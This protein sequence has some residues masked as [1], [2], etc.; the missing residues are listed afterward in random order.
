MPNSISAA[1]IEFG[2]PNYSVN[3]YIL[4]TVSGGFRQWRIVC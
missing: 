1:I 3:N 2:G 4:D